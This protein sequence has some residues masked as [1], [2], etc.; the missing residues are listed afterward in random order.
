MIL[1]TGGTGY[2][3]SHTCLA[4]SLAKVNGNTSANVASRI[5]VLFA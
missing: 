5:C 3:G 4:L 1:I 2:I